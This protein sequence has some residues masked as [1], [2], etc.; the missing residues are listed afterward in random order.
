MGNNNRTNRY[1]KGTR[2]KRLHVSACR[3]F[4]SADCGVELAGC[5]E[6]E[7]MNVFPHGFNL[8]K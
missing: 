6:L 3:W 4:N 7:E 8:S 5:I 1:T 2:Q